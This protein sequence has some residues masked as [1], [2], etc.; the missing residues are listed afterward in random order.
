MTSGLRKRRFV[1][2]VR[3]IVDEPALAERVSRS[4]VLTLLVAAQGW[5]ADKTIVPNKNISVKIDER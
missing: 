5:A 4:N 1:R 3:C 2:E